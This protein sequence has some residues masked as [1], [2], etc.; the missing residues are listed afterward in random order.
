LSVG[1]FLGGVAD[2]LTFGL[3]TMALGSS[4]NQC[5]KAFS[6]GVWVG[7]GGSLVLTGGA[8]GVGFFAAR[9]LMKGGFKKLLARGAA[10]RVG[11]GPA[12]GFLEVSDAYKS[13]KAVQ[14]FSSSRHTD[15]IYDP[16]SRQFIMG[17][18]SHGHDSILNAGRI[19]PHDSIVGGRISRQN[20]RLVTDE[21]SGQYG[22][23]WTPEI[24]QQFQNFMQQH[25]VRVNHTPWGR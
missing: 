10:K 11:S 23:N 6:A 25:G 16:K 9:A 22:Q 3:S 13:S 1:D 4:I 2:G 14:N 18:G 7:F 17:R 8:G 19:S 21:W 5:S 15:F 24:R 12:K 20:G